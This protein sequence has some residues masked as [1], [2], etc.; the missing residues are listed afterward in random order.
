[1]PSASTIPL[2]TLASALIVL[3]G[4]GTRTTTDQPPASSPPTVAVAPD[5]RDQNSRMGVPIDPE[6]AAGLEGR[7]PKVEDPGPGVPENIA[8]ALT[9][10]AVPLD[11]HTDTVVGFDVISEILAVAAGD[12]ADQL[13]ALLSE[14]FRGGLVR[15]GTSGGVRTHVRLG[16]FSTPEAAVRADQLLVLPMEGVDG[17]EL[18][19]RDGIRLFSSTGTVDG[20]P[21]EWISARI[22]VGDT[23]V[24]ISTPAPDGADLAVALVEDQA[25]RLR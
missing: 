5:L 11:N 21:V 15:T 10:A 13:R 25:G 8:K 19:G 7:G 17:R 2:V 24:E 3:G 4:C 1:M 14:S 22:V 16:R 6:V 18:D 12:Q 20:E 9:A 23:L